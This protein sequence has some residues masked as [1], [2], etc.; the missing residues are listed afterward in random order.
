MGEELYVQ[1][2]RES[3]LIKAYVREPD[4]SPPHGV[5]ETARLPSETKCIALQCSSFIN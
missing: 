2:L 3:S 5:P 1:A 4:I